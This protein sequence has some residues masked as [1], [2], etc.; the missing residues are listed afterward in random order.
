MRE[1]DARCSELR[2]SSPEGLEC[3]TVMTVDE[4]TIYVSPST[5]KCTNLGD[6][7]TSLLAFTESYM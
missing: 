6:L 7:T 1:D 5:S 3:P 4:G 2:L